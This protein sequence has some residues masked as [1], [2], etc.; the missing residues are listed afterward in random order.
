MPQARSVA[1]FDREAQAGWSSD[2]SETAELRDVAVDLVAGADVGGPSSSMRC[3]PDGAARYAFLVRDPAG[4]LIGALTLAIAGPFKREE[5]QL[6]AAL[7]ARIAPLLVLL[8]QDL[9]RSRALATIHQR[10]EKTMQLEWLHASTLDEEESAGGDP[11]ERLLRAV[12][13]TLEA[14]VVIASVPGHQFERLYAQPGAPLGDQEALRNV[15]VG[16]LAR[17]VESEGQSL[18]VSKAR[19]SAQS[20]AFRFVCTPLR[21][22]GVGIGVLVAFA[23]LERRSFGARDMR[24][25]ERSA[26]RL[27]EYVDSR[28][29]PATGLPSRAVLEDAVLAAGRSGKRAQCLVYMDIDQMHALNDLFGFDTGD[30]VLRRLAA[31]WPAGRIVEGGLIGRLSGDRFAAV[32]D[33]CT[34][35][36]GRAWAEAARVQVERLVLPETSKGFKLSASFGVATIEAGERFETALARAS[37]AGRAAKD[38]GRNRVELFADTDLSLLQR[39]DDLKLFRELCMAI[40]ARRFQMLAHT[41]VPLADPSRPMQ[42]ELLVRLVDTSGALLEPGRF[43]SAATRYQLLPQLD[44]AIIELALSE[45]APYASLLEAHGAVCWINITGATIGQ[46]D[47]ADAVRLMVKGSGIPGHL[48]GFEITEGAA[49]ENVDAATRFIQRVRELGCNVA[50]DDFGTGFS[51][52]AYLKALAAQSI[53]IDGSF[54]RDLLSNGRSQALV[55]AVLEIAR[56]LGL[57]TTA[58][59]VESAEVAARLKSLGVTYGQGHYFGKPQPLGDVLSALADAA[60]PAVAAQA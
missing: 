4:A 10:M 51:S 16:P 47:V 45:L 29:D 31:F 23:N 3:V 19:T 11:I 12:A 17:R 25:L 6:P 46:P 34:L 50:L 39:Q 26:P 2:D 13:E 32:L 55:S 38:R 49:I 22:H 14:D 33:D 1:I 9:A 44:R 57:D 54:I 53:K 15:A 35:N 30:D 40:E 28:V 41:L 5:L 27:V 21:R 37:T 43:L 48:I 20:P 59:Y 52:L 24:L 7:E 18:C 42:Y 36:L 60:P 8:A 58:E 56:Q